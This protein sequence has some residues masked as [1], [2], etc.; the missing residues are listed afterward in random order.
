[1]KTS[2]KG[3]MMKLILEYEIEP[4]L[5]AD[6]SVLKEMTDKEIFD[7]LDEDWSGIIECSEKRIVR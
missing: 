7:M 1:M 4:S 2:R 6:E 3:D 5:W